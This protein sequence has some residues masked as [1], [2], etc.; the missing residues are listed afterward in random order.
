[1]LAV[2]ARAVG[3]ETTASIGRA[4][5]FAIAIWNAGAGAADVRTAAAA[6]LVAWAIAAGHDVVALVG[7]LSALALAR[8]GI[9]AARRCQ[10]EAVELRQRARRENQRNQRQPHE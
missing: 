9:R 1:M 3:A 5:G 7:E 8:V 6:R 4:A 10:I 2:W